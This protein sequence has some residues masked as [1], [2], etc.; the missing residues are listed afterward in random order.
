ME[1]LVGHDRVRV[2]KIQDGS[3]HPGLFSGSGQWLRL[4]VGDVVFATLGDRVET[5]RGHVSR[6]IAL[7]SVVRCCLSVLVPRE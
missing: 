1:I 5:S 6:Q 3:S 7:A 2:A 4:M